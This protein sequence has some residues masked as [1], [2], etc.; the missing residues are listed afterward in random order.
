MLKSELI[1]WEIILLPYIIIVFLPAQCRLF[2]VTVVDCYILKFFYDSSSWMTATTRW[3]CRF[4]WKYFYDRLYYHYI[5]MMITDLI[6]STLLINLTLLL[7]YLS[8][9]I[10]RYFF[11]ANLSLSKFL[12]SFDS[13]DSAR[14]DKLPNICSILIASYKEEEK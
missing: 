9:T 4:H 10:K 2:T 6:W 1:F 13:L 7:S 11:L 8:L 12:F 14:I 3:D 5:D